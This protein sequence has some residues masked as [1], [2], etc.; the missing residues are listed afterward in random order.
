MRQSAVAFSEFWHA[1][2]KAT[3]D[4]R[5]IGR[6]LFRVLA[7]PCAHKPRHAQ[8][9]ECCNPNP[10]NPLHGLCPDISALCVT[11]DVR[12]IKEQLLRSPRI[13]KT[14]QRSAR[15]RK[16]CVRVESPS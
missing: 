8:P 12:T 1:P 11:A 13:M 14:H 6:S 5:M 10:V 3:A 7:C 4:W 16:Q 15:L 2:E 9:G